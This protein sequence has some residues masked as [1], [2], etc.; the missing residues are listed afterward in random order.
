MKNNKNVKKERKL[1]SECFKRKTKELKKESDAKD[2][3]C[4]CLFKL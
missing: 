4:V 1:F 3:L 2:I